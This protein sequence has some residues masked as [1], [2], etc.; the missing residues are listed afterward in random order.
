MFVWVYLPS[1]CSDTCLVPTALSLLRSFG[2]TFH[3]PLPHPIHDQSMGFNNMFKAMGR[4][5]K[6]RLKDI[7]TL[8]TAIDLLNIAKDTVEILPV[9]G[10]LGSAIS[11]LTLIRVS[12][13]F[14]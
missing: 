12:H 10:V 1:D 7:S 4:R 14:S 8:D 5:S 9:K 2:L 11:L 6:E 3:S 13:H